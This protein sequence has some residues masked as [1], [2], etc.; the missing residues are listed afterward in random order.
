MIRDENLPRNQWRLGR[1]V[2]AVPDKD[3][4]VRKVR[5]LVGTAELDARGK[6]IESQSFLDRPIHKLVLIQESDV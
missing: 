4:L 1:V 2:E 3:G 5:I 6:R